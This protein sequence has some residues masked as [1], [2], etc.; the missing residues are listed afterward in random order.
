MNDV[1]VHHMKNSGEY[2]K[3]TDKTGIVRCMYRGM[4]NP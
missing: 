3:G 4:M 1:G 2:V